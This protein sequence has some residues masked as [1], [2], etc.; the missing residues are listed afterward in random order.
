MRLLFPFTWALISCRS[1]KEIRCSHFV[2]S[3][4]LSLIRPA[5]VGLQ[6][7]L[8]PSL[9]GLPARCAGNLAWAGRVVEVVS[10]V[11]VSCFLIS[12]SSFVDFFGGRMSFPMRFGPSSLK[13]LKR[14][15]AAGS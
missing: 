3:W 12:L 9:L 15:L 5:G 4:L 8:V 7:V 13:A 1:S 6:T 10:G 14:N 2:L 11:T